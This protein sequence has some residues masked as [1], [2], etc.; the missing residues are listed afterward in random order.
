MSQY[1]TKQEPLTEML[2]R[3]EGVKRN[4]YKCSA[5]VLTIG[6]GRN[7]ESVGLSDDE[8]FYMLKNDIRRCDEELDNAFRWYEHLKQP[9][10]DAMISLCFNLGIN[11]LRG[12]KRALAAMEMDSYEEAASEFLDSKWATQVGQR[13]I[14]LTDMIR[15]GEYDA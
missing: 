5:G 10:K 11:R 13:A 14:E 2:M 9:R 7:L 8:I 1:S 4:P 15:T 12:F 3:H 6:I